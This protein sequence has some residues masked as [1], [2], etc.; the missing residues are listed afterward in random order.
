MGISF[1]PQNLDQAIAMAVRQAKGC[2]ESGESFGRLFLTKRNGGL[3]A[4]IEKP[5][6]NVAKWILSVSDADTEIVKYVY[7]QIKKKGGLATLVA[8]CPCKGFPQII[9]PDDDLLPS[10]RW[11]DALIDAAE[12]L[13]DKLDKIKKEAT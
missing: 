5:D 8:E 11:L 2:L 6:V 4:K 13:S 12:T 9:G 10:W 7:L 1:N 3:L